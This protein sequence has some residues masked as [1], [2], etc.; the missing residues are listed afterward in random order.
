LR[1]PKPESTLARVS[2]CA[3]RT[4]TQ[5]IPHTIQTAEIRVFKEL[6]INLL[7]PV[8]SFCRLS[9]SPTDIGLSPTFWSR[10]DEEK[11]K[12]TT[13]TP[14]CNF[15]AQFWESGEPQIDGWIGL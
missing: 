9:L 3:Q 13:F 6:Q 15:N 4:T 2:S 12:I 14:Q 1:K 10:N 8:L 5:F 11:Q 7:L